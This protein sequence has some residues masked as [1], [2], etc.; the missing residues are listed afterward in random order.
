M[1]F[2]DQAADGAY[3][4]LFNGAHRGSVWSAWE[5][6]EFPE[7]YMLPPIQESSICNGNGL[8]N[9]GFKE[10]DWLR[11]YGARAAAGAQ[12]IPVVPVSL[13]DKYSRTRDS[14]S[15]AS[16]YTAQRRLTDSTNVWGSL[17]PRSSLDLRA[18]NTWTPY[19]SSNAIDALLAQDTQHRRSTAY[20]PRRTGSSYLR[21][22]SE[23]L[24]ATRLFNPHLN[25][26]WRR[27]TTTAVNDMAITRPLGRQFFGNE[28]DV[29]SEPAFLYKCDALTDFCTDTGLL[30]RAATNLLEPPPAIVSSDTAELSAQELASI[31]RDAN[32]QLTSLGSIP[33][34]EGTCNWT[35][36]WAAQLMCQC[37]LP[38]GLC[39][40]CVFVNNPKR[41]GCANGLRC[42]YCHF[43]HVKK[44]V[45][46]YVN[47]ASGHH[48]M[49]SLTDLVNLF[50]M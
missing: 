33:H 48:D 29:L 36:F 21:S 24:L 10:D 28:N 7:N 20:E 16:L 9:G 35:L 18:L 47:T 32:N 46:R 27:S 23:K 11:W 26:P 6:A 4:G 17:F 42:G 37:L 44:K 50:I 38:S 34:A 8:S 43:P 15:N 45:P 12:Q 22:G 41:E 1:S 19:G 30:N 13:S 40:P 39:R 49:T 3:M 25:Q 5:N 31:P 2:E 14:I